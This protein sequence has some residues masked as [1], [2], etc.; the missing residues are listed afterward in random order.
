MPGMN[1]PPL[2]GYHWTEGDL[3]D[4]RDHRRDMDHAYNLGRAFRR[5]FIG[6][7]Q[8][9]YRLAPALWHDPAELSRA[10]RV[11]WDEEHA[12]ERRLIRERGND[13]TAT[14]A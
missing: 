11:G 9:P 7:D 12:E 3:L 5:S 8:D 10:F 2:L 14:A 4:D 13:A 6:R 1:L